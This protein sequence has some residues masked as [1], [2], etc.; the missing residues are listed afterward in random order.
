MKNVP[1]SKPD[2]LNSDIKRVNKTIK[3]GWLTNGKNS[4]EFEKLFC[5]YTGAKFSTTILSI[6]GPT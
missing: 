6:R 2:I 4:Q 1:F 5:K 3:S